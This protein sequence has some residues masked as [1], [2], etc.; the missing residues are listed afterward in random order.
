[1]A[2]QSKR[3]AIFSK[4]EGSAMHESNK[5]SCLCGEVSFEITG[6]FDSFYLCHCKYCQKDTGSAHAANLF[7]TT[8]QIAWKSGEDKINSYKHNGTRHQRSFCNK[9][10]SA[11]PYTA[12]EGM[13]LVVPAGCLDESI[14]IKPKAH[15]FMASQANWEIHLPE[16]PKFDK[17]PG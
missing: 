17:F 3:K 14:S 13:L 16:T 10:G 1:M 12:N 7:S 5:G 9:C 15:I 8:A 6:G 2:L 4:L 11:L